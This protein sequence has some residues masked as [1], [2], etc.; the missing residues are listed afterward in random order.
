MY[1]DVLYAVAAWMQR[2]GYVQDV[3]YVVCAGAHKRRCT[4]LHGCRR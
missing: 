4:R 1:M 3:M 2:S